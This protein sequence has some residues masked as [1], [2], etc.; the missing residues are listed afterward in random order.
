MGKLIFKDFVEGIDRKLHWRKDGQIKQ[1][2]ERVREGCINLGRNGLLFGV[3]RM[4][5]LLAY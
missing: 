2:A 5:P 4:N 3:G 1:D